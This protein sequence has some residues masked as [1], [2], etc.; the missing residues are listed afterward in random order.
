MMYELYILLFFSILYFIIY[1]NK[2]LYKEPYSKLEP[3]YEII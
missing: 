2:H 3:I 1:L